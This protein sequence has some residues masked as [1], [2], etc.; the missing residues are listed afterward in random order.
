LP[1]RNPDRENVQTKRL[2][3]CI[4]MSRKDLTNAR[5]QPP[6]QGHEWKSFLGLMMVDPACSGGCRAAVQLLRS[7]EEI[8][9][10]ELARASGLQI[11][12]NTLQFDL[13]L[14]RLVREAVMEPITTAPFRFQLRKTG[15]S[16][17]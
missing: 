2:K 5:S 13:I 8:S 15:N 3:A 9:R 1:D 10:D 7:Q 6:E 11:Y 14:A 16:I 4:S 12:C 17:P